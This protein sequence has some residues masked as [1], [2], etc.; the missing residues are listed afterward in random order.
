MMLGPMQGAH[1]LV[2]DESVLTQTLAP[3][4]VRDPERVRF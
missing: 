1:S 3:G 4:L 2:K